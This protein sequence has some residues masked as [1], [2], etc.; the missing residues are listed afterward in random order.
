MRLALAALLA[1]VAPAPTLAAPTPAGEDDHAGWIQDF[2]AAVDVAKREKKDLFVDFTGSDWCSWCIRLNKEVFVHDEFLEPIRKKYVLV[3]LDYP[4]KPEAL[5]RVPNRERNQEVAQRYQIDGYP[6]VVLMTAEGEEYG[7]MGYQ[8]GGPLAYVEAIEEL[9]PRR[10]TLRE[11]L[12]RVA[13]F[14]AAKGEEARDL[15]LDRAITQLAA[16]DHDAPAIERLASV[17]RAAFDV[18][19]SGGKGLK[20]RAIRALVT[21]RQADYEVVQ[22][23]LPLDP[24]NAD[25]FREKTILAWC[26]A[27]TSK[28]D[29][30][31]VTEA[32]AE[33]DGFGIKDPKVAVEL[34]V[35]AAFWY[36]RFLADG[37]QAKAYARKARAI[38]T[39]VE[40]YEAMLAQILGE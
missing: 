30:A 8:P 35:N 22:Q 17:A 3:M 27:V 7:R 6:T 12:K 21:S 18:D 33:V 32:I 11:I 24:R 39:D 2:D 38:G 4:Q 13:E 20:Q 25:G 34:Y 36:Q 19:Q 26:G 29:L 23:A 5:A 9:W 1:A 10:D 40:E 37:E 15:A 16:M 28:A 31:P 14:E